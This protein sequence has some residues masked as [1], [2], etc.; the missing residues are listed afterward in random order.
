MVVEPADGMWVRSARA[1][2]R[3][4][5]SFVVAALPD[6]PVWQM[7]GSA[8]AVWESLATPRRLDDHVATVAAAVGADPRL[9][10]DGVV[11]LVDD[12]VRR[13]LVECR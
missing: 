10:H 8:S 11:R 7:T 3:V 5:S 9:V 12:L 13:G 6:G 1:I 4:T 2:S